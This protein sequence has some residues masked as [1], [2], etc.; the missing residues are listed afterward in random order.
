M[1]EAMHCPRHTGNKLMP[2]QVVDRL[3]LPMSSAGT[4]AC[5][6]SRGCQSAAGPCSSGRRQA[7]SGHSSRVP[8][9]AVWALVEDGLALVRGA[10]LPRVVLHEGMLALGALLVHLA[11]LARRQPPHCACQARRHPRLGP[12]A[13]KRT[14]A[15][16]RPCCCSSCSTSSSL[17]SCLT[18]G[19]RLKR[20][21]YSCAA[22]RSAP[23]AAGGRAWQRRQQRRGAL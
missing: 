11:Q 2:S 7:G 16:V 21:R 23:Q 4:C 10:Q 15:R 17:L 13:G 6:I 20:R 3:A 5:R 12:P 18:R 8:A 19:S 22:P 14:V 9:P 1:Q